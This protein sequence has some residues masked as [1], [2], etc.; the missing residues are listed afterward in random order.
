MDGVVVEGVA[1][2][3]EVVDGGIVCLYKC[4]VVVGVENCMNDNIR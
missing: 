2:V 4:V 1:V 3:A